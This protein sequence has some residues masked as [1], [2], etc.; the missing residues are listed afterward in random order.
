M[1]RTNGTW[2][3]I[4]PDLFNLDGGNNHA[5]TLEI[6]RKLQVQFIMQTLTA[7]ALVIQ[8]E[9]RYCSATGFVLGQ[10]RL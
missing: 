8:W 9:I 10:C 4:V 5:W 7:M 3:L 2:T 6:P 1:E